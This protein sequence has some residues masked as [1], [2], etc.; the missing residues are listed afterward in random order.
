MCKQVSEKREVGYRGEGEKE[1]EGGKEKERGREGEGERKGR[2]EGRRKP[3]PWPQGF[4]RCDFSSCEAFLYFLFSDA[5]RYPCIL[6]KN[7]A[8]QSFLFMPLPDCDMLGVLT[9][10]GLRWSSVSHREE[11][12]G[13]I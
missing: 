12:R 11:E 6:P 9:S 3:L 1:G 10:R 13:V 5:M 8:K 4:G 7:K 2:R